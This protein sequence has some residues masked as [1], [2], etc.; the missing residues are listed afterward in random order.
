MYQDYVYHLTVKDLSGVPLAPN[1]Y[2]SLQCSLPSILYKLFL[3]PQETTKGF[4]MMDDLFVRVT[5][6]IYRKYILYPHFVQII[7][8]NSSMIVRIEFLEYIYIP[9]A[10]RRN[11][12]FELKPW[13]R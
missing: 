3:I 11:S 7:H 10:N 9:K 2:P 1:I 8:N 5:E 12:Y 13:E 6:P 4:L